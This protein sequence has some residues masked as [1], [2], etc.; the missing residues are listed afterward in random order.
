MVWLRLSVDSTTYRW[1]CYRR[2]N[3]EITRDPQTKL[4]RPKVRAAR[5]SGKGCWLRYALELIV[6]RLCSSQFFSAPLYSPIS[7]LSIVQTTANCIVITRIPVIF[8]YVTFQRIYYIT[9]IAIVERHFHR[10][11]RL[12]R[13]A[14]LIQHISRI[15]LLLNL[16]Y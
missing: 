2:K 5:E 8:V 13:C 1:C 10:V 7:T 14:L 12:R 11:L 16:R 3:L 4:F 15:R 9:P 6:Q